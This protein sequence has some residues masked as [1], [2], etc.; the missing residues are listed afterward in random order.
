MY[1]ATVRILLV[2]DNDIVRLAQTHALQQFPDI[3]LSDHAVD[4]LSAVRKAAEARPEVILMDIGLPGID[5]IEATTL[6]KD[7]QPECGILV[8]TS[9]S[10]D[11]AIFHALAAGADAFCRKDI[12]ADMLVKV[13]QLVA[14]GAVWLDPSVAT[15]ILAHCLVDSRAADEL[16][17]FNFG[18]DEKFAISVAEYE[19]LNS[20]RE[21]R[22]S[23]DSS[24]VNG[25]NLN[26]YIGKDQHLLQEEML[27]QSLILRKLFSRI[28]KRRQVKCDCSH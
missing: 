23:G 24:N 2:E 1:P 6:I 12:A 21:N 28:A 13:I 22:F 16:A 17:I 5:G 9:E 14:K 27:V 3:V 18:E 19:A 15:R 20:F 26:P 11:Q 4:G 25:S 7:G 10:A 8:I